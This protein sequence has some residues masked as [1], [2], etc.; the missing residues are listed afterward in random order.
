MHLSLLCKDVDNEFKCFNRV[1][2]LIALDKVTLLDHLHIEYVINEANKQVN[3]TNDNYN[4]SA[5]LLVQNLPK[6]ALQKHQR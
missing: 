6:Q 3:L 1:E 2:V 5:H 4:R